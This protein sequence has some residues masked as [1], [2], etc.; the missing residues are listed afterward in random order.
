MHIRRPNSLEQRGDAGR[1][2]E[3][4][5]V[6]G[7][8]EAYWNRKRR[9]HGALIKSN[10]QQNPAVPEPIGLLK[11]KFQ[12]ELNDPWVVGRRDSAVGGGCQSAV[13]KLEIY[14]VKDIEELGAKL[15]GSALRDWSGLQHSEISVKRLRTPQHV[16]SGVAKRACGILHKE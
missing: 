2:E 16:P 3:R 7:C 12:G 13:R 9:V 5:N 11:G 6:L 14:I 4:G 10:R 15:E 1:F 8:F